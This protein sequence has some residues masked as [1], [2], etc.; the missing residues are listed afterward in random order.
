MVSSGEVQQKT[1]A[2]QEAQ[3]TAVDGMRE[4]ALQDTQR[5]FQAIRNTIDRKEEELCNRIVAVSG[6]KKHSIEARVQSCSSEGESLAAAQTALSFLL[7]NGSS[8]E[9]VACRRLANVRQSAAT[10]QCRGGAGGAPVSP[11]VRFLP[12][13]EE[14]LLAAIRE[15]GHIQEGASPLHCTCLLYTSPSPRDS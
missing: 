8:H 11:V 3:S 4:R 7:A 13:Q 2:G 14:A 15:F 10:S 5:T 6:E 12:Q 1:A 9:V